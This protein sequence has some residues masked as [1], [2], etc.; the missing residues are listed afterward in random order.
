VHKKLRSKRL[1]PVLIKEITRRCHLEGIFQAIYTGGVVLPTPISTCRYY[2]RTLNVPKLVDAKFTYVPRNM[3][4]ARM[5]RQFKAPS[6]LALSRSGLRE[7]EDRDV[8]AVTELFTRYTARFDMAPLL[9][10]EDV[11][12]QFLSG[13]GKGDREVS[14]GRREGQVVWSYVVEVSFTTTFLYQ[15]FYNGTLES[16]ISRHYRLLLVLY[17]TID[18]RVEPAA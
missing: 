11:R 6:T 13:R 5:V 14:T 7:M 18:G 15:Q 17:L 9:E 12:H 1:T 8:P 2:H 10:E 4:I 16:G 3:T